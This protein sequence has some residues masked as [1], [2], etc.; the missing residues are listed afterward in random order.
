[1]NETAT[2]TSLRKLCESQHRKLIVTIVTTVFGLL[3]LIPLVDDYFDKKESHRRL[4]DELAE[5]RQTAQNLPE[6][7]RRVAQVANDLAVVESR[8]VSEGSLSDYRSTLVEMVRNAGCQVRKITVGSPTVRPWSE[9]DDPLVW[10]KGAKTKKRPTP[11]VLERRNIVLLVDGPNESVHDF[12]KK[13]HQDK[14]FT[15]PRRIDLRSSSTTGESVALE[16][17]LWVFALNPREA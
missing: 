14:T 5:S 1:M 3:V 9:D 7:E 15:Y 6:F 8:S 10:A 13:L 11:F 2:K 17:E 4:T 12:I 16:L